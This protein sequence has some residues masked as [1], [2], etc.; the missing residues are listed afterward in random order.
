MISVYDYLS[1]ENYLSEVWK[2]KKEKNSQFSVRSWAKQLG[3]KY[4]A[5]LHQI[6]IG[7]R[8]IPKHY[9]P[10]LITNL[11]LDA[12]EA[13]YLETLVDLQKAKTNEEKEI[14]GTRLNLLTPKPLLKMVKLE[15]Y[16]YFQ[17]PLHGILLEMSYLKDFVAEPSW[18]QSRIGFKVSIV[19]IKMTLDRLVTLGFMERNEKG[20]LTKTSRHIFTKSDIPNKYI[21]EYHV[22]CSEMA[23]S[24]LSSQD[25]LEREFNA[26]TFNIA[27]KDIPRA[28]EI[29]RRYL[30]DFITDIEAPPGVGEETYHINLQLFKITK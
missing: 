22:R 13:L 26:S 10:L 16:K 2:I 6:L 19:D 23:K 3:M 5:P 30:N 25:V 8:K 24:A 12:K 1:A 11:K 21:N 7:K 17:D 15:T 14:Y 4:H 20:H 9:L 28:K 29:L 27:K 18:I